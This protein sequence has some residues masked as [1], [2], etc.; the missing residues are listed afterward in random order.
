MKTST[1]I[2]PLTALFASAVTAQS[3]CDPVA[4][5]IPSCGVPCIQS[6]AVAIGC[7]AN[8]Y[9]CRCSSASAIQASAINCVLGNC[10]LA[11]A[12]QVQASASAVCGCV[13]TAAP[14]AR[15]P[16]RNVAVMTAA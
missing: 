4:S 13:A 10:G 9:A 3:A 7:D 5:A 6:A 16:R 2:A 1:I 12:L 15:K 14:D 8:S 11:T